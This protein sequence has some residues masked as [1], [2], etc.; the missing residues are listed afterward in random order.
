MAWGP[1]GW[2]APSFDYGGFGR[3]ASFSGS[4]TTAS[5]WTPLGQLSSG[6]EGFN[7]NGLW[8]SP[9]GYLL[10]GFDGRRRESFWFSSNGLAWLEMPRSGLS[11]DA[12]IQVLATPVGF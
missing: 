6:A 2:L 10:W 9:I 11:T 12:W 8:G 7:L 3:R 1:S 4:P 5:G